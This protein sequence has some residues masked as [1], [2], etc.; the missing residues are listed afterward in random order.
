M[1][2]AISVSQRAAS[3]TSVSMCRCKRSVA[4]VVM[5]ETVAG[6]SSQIHNTKCQLLQ[7][8]LPRAFHFP[9]EIHVFSA[10]LAVELRREPQ[11]KAAS[12][13]TFPLGLRTAVGS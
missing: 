12:K 9:S 2:S 4:I 1:S 8:R 5:H 11:L 10:R 7:H 6:I 3:S 13:P